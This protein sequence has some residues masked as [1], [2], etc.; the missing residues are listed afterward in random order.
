MIAS[1]AAEASIDPGSVPASST[2]PITRTP[3]PTADDVATAQSMNPG[4][5][6]R[7]IRDMVAGLAPRLAANPDDLEVWKRLGK[8]YLVLSEPATAHQ[9]NARA[10]ARAPTDTELLA[11]YA[12]ATLMT[13]G[14]NEI[15][16]Q[17]VETL[18]PVL[19]ADASNTTAQWFV[20]L[21]E[22]GAGHVQEAAALWKR[23]LPELQPDTP[24]RIEALGPAK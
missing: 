1:V 3:G 2:A 4:D 12:N 24:A 18:R 8:S 17:S 9:A 16:P 23:L 14:P 6:Q 10:A 20:G 11:A 13:P 15:P 5:Q 21:A 19:K 22:S 7:M